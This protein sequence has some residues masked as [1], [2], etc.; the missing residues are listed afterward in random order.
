VKL[1]Y[2]FSLKEIG[3]D[4]L[5]ASEVNMKK[6]GKL[7]LGAA[8][9]WPVVYMF[10][11]FI[12]I[13]SMVFIRVDETGPGNL[14]ASI[15]S[16]FTLHIFTMLLVMGLTIFYIVDVFRNERVEKDK[17]VLWAIV[18]FM[19]NMIGMPIYWYLYFWKD[20]IVPSKPSPARLNSVDTSAWTNSTEAARQEQ[21]QYVPPSQPPNWRE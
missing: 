9:L 7:L 13:F 6:S 4:S 11:F 10:I 21:H 5:V 3:Y 16:I 8:T 12:F 19:G 17:K 20:P 14:G 15:A 2:W 18:I 1:V